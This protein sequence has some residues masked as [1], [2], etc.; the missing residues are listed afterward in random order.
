MLLALC[1]RVIITALFHTYATDLCWDYIVSANLTFERREG[2]L[3]V[4]GKKE[5]APSRPTMALKN[6][7]TKACNTIRSY[8]QALYCANLALA[9]LWWH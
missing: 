6:G 1:F 5:M 3:T 4:R 8:A 7:R 9:V 2:V